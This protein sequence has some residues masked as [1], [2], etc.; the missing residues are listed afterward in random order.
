MVWGKNENYGVNR[1]F[2]E[3]KLITSTGISARINL[4]GQLI[5]EPYYAYPL[6][7][8]GLNGG[9]FGVNFTPGW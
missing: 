9:V 2:N 5:I 8:K 4:F 3:T 7:L 1:T 6:Q